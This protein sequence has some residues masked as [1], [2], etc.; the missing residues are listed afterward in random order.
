M[1]WRAGRNYVNL[2][3]GAES[4]VSYLMARLTVEK[5]FRSEQKIKHPPKKLIE[6]KQAQS[7]SLMCEWYN[8][9]L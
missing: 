6:I 9:F 2:N 5:S 4:T 7:I 3:Q 1:L 8:S